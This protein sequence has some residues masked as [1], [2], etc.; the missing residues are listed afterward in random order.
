MIHPEAPSR[1]FSSNCQLP[2]ILFYLYNARIHTILNQLASDDDPMSVDIIQVPDTEDST[3]VRH[4]LSTT[5]PIEYWLTVH[6]N[7]K[8][9][10]FKGEVTIEISA[11]QNTDT[12][13]LHSENLAI[14]EV[15]VTTCEKIDGK[16]KKISSNFEPVNTREY[17]II[18]TEQPLLVEHHYKVKITFVRC[19]QGDSAQIDDNVSSNKRKKSKIPTSGSKK[20]T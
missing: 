3:I 8:S 4:L 19:S 1:P 13:V 11:V 5:K 2:H 15:V 9:Q 12:I 17:L 14:N 20:M 18:K 6:P 16:V 7:I 10:T